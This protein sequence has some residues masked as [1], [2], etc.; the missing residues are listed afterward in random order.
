MRFVWVFALFLSS[1]VVH[2]DFSIDSVS[3]VGGRKKGAVLVD[4]EFMSIDEKRNHHLTR[5]CWRFRIIDR[6]VHVKEIVK[7]ITQGN[8][9]IGGNKS[10]S[11]F[12]ELPEQSRLYSGV[13]RSALSIPA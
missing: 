6:A 13:N 2:I 10:L 3:F 9:T 7:G 4:V 11:I 1:F 5:L 12:A 8:F